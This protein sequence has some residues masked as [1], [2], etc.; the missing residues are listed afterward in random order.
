[1]K[2]RINNPMSQAQIRLARLFLAERELLQ[3]IEEVDGR[4]PTDAEILKHGRHVTLAPSPLATF[5]RDNQQWSKFY[6]WRGTEALAI[7]FLDA[8][9]PL[10]I[11]T[12]RMTRDEWPAALAATIANNALLP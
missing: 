4:V 12:C 8:G 1:M 5:V 3:F 11:R 7:D 9:D 6:V 10:V 2:P